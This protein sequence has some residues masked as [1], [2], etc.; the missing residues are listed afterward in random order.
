MVI[1]SSN[2]KIR[3]EV[4]RPY[5]LLFSKE[6]NYSFEAFV[7]GK[8]TVVSIEDSAECSTSTSD[9]ETDAQAVLLL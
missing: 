3:R 7:N 2:A 6:I 4:R 9:T 8:Q 5:F 1:V